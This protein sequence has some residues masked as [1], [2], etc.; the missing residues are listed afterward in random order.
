M[1]QLSPE[2]LKKTL[3]LFPQITD[4]K[5]IQAAWRQ[6]K[7]TKDPVSR[8][9]TFLSNGL[10]EIKE[11][12]AGKNPFVEYFQK[13]K[14]LTHYH[15]NTM[16]ATRNEFPDVPD[17]VI[18]DM[19]TAQQRLFIP[20]GSA[21]S[22]ITPETTTF[23]EKPYA[24]RPVSRDQVPVG[25]EDPHY[26]A[27]QKMLDNPD[28]SREYFRCFELQQ[29]FCMRYPLLD[30]WKRHVKPTSTDDSFKEECSS[31]QKSFPFSQLA[32][33]SAGCAT[34]A[35]CIRS[36]YDTREVNP[37]NKS[38][39]LKCP[40]VASHTIA[41]D[42]VLNVVPAKEIAKWRGQSVADAFPADTVNAGVCA[43]CY[44]PLLPNWD[45]DG[46]WICSRAGCGRIY[47]FL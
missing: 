10:R 28:T 29:Q 40:T 47:I 4:S 2:D 7:E 24:P 35:S 44:F 38:V 17:D 45:F 15:R 14:E 9:V 1:A 6:F 21:L 3:S 34:C 8:I 42:F 32:F 30:A 26:T 5:Y 36:Q 27:D 41:P 39:T 12:R 46:E 37:A 13:N 25:A 16:I 33:C 20:V 22:E 23:K 31:C 19:F 43:S 11:R 18:S